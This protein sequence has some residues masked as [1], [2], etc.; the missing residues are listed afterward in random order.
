[1]TT[2]SYNPQQIRSFF[3]EICL[4]IYAAT[5]K[6]NETA[7]LYESN[8]G[9]NPQG[10][11]HFQTYENKWGTQYRIYFKEID[12]N[13]VLLNSLFKVHENNV[14]YLK[15]FTHRINDPSLFWNLVSCGCRLG[16]NP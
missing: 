4:E 5:T 11:P 9:I 3:G 13:L 10:D 8:T 14:T 6:L 7:Q 15:D 16:I 1:M 2:P 12:S